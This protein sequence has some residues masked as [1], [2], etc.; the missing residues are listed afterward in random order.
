[1]SDSN[2]KRKRTKLSPEQTVAL[3][4]L[5]AKTNPERPTFKQYCDANQ[6]LLGESGSTKRRF[7]QKHHTN[8]KKRGIL[9][10][11]KDRSKYPVELVRSAAHSIELL[12]AKSESSS[13]SPKPK[14]KKKIISPS[15][16]SSPQLQRRMF[17]PQ[18]IRHLMEKD[19]ADFI[20]QMNVDEPFRNIVLVPYRVPQCPEIYPKAKVSKGFLDKLTLNLG[21]VDIRD[22]DKYLL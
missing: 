15:P 12:Q 11:V 6:E 5:F 18:A 16:F 2:N 22:I 21:I 13:L 17:S 8:W 1:M 4:S 14:A 9:S 20:L 7:V 3:L 19:E 10:L